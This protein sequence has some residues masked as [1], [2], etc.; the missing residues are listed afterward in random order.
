VWK[1]YI[2]DF[3][4]GDDG[5]VNGGWSLEINTGVTPTTTHNFLDFD[6]D[7]KTDY[8]VVRNSAGTL[9]WYLQRSTSG[10]AGQQWGVTGDV[11]PA[12][13]LQVR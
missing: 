11:R 7:N 1:L 6:G 13:T 2:G 9:F 5:A 12:N 10:F 3:V 8:A 4:D